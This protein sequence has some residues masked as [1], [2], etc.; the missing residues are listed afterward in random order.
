VLKSLPLRAAELGATSGPCP[1][2][3]G[4]TTSRYFR[5]AKTSI[6]R[7]I[8][9]GDLVE[10]TQLA[11]RELSTS[12]L[13][14]SI[15]SSR[16]CASSS[17]VAHGL[18]SDGSCGIVRSYPVV[19]PGRGSRRV[20]PP[21]SNC[22]YLGESG[23]ADH[24]RHL[25]DAGRGGGRSGSARFGRDRG[26]DQSRR[27]GRRLSVRAFWRAQ[28]LVDEGDAAAASELLANRADET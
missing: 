4:G 22:D 19:T 9:S 5:T 25:W 11:K 20:T 8:A 10:R 23:R 18:S 16:V 15:T 1:I 7:A 27:R 3:R 6:V 17:A 24:D 21:A 13:I 28:V 14:A 2:A 26:I 12:C